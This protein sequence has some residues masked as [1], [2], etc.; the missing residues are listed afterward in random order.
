MY[1][2]LVFNPSTKVTKRIRMLH[3][4]IS[5]VTSQ[6]SPFIVPIILKML[7]TK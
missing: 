4:W 5:M 1:S 2:E 7:S 3:S 6:L